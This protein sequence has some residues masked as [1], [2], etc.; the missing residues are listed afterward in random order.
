MT[1][2]HLHNPEDSMKSRVGLLLD[3]SVAI[4]DVSDVFRAAFSL[5]TYLCF[6]A[7]LWCHHIF[8]QSYSFTKLQLE[9]AVPKSENCFNPRCINS[10]GMS[11][12]EPA[13]IW[14]VL[15]TGKMNQI[16]RCDWIPEG[17]IEL[18]C[19]SGL[20]AVSPEKNFSE[21]HIIEPLLAKLVRSIWLD[22]GLILFLRVYGPRFRVGP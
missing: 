20:H 12:K 11:A 19:H 15:W 6:H 9:A 16:L 7:A 21:I 14:L 3:T 18:F 2:K 5:T 22:I 13:I 1:S 10:C 4:S 8:V 17:K